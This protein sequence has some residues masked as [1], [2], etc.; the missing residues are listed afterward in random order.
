MQLHEFNI[1][2]SYCCE[3]VEAN[4]PWNIPQLATSHR[5][6]RLLNTHTHT[7]ESPSAKSVLL[8]SQQDT[9]ASSNTKCYGTILK[10]G[11]S[12]FPQLQRY[13]KLKVKSVQTCTD[14]CYIEMIQINYNVCNVLFYILSS[15][16]RT[17]LCFTD[18]NKNL[19]P[20]I[21]LISCRQFV[22]YKVL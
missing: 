12:G 1:S 16:L 17:F 11:T 13:L 3:S 21:L 5:L 2:E 18:L 20:D 14:A 4:D 7:E 8:F 15:T 22:E 9:A 19:F 6:T 10:E